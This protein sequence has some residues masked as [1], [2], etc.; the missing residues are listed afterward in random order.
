[1]FRFITLM[2]PPTKKRK[3]MRTM[4]RRS[5]RRSRPVALANPPR[6]AKRRRVG[7]AR[8][9]RHHSPAMRAKISRA[10]KRA[11][12]SRRSGGGSIR[13]MR[14]SRPMAIARRRSSRRRSSASSG[15]LYVIKG[16][17][18]NP[19]RRNR[20][21]S[22][23]RRNPDFN[24][25]SLRGLLSKDIL[26]VAAG[27]VTAS[28]ATGYVLNKFGTSLPMATST[29]GLMAYQLAIPMIGAYVLR[30]KYKSFA[31]GLAVGGIVMAITSVMKTGLGTVGA[32]IVQTPMG[33]FALAGEIGGRRKIRGLNA[34]IGPKTYHTVPDAVNAPVFASG[35]WG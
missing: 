13:R 23:R 35:A 33:S 7:V 28:V 14:R 18:L 31:V 4:R 8:K 20:R 25:S 10:V 11:M 32:S 22:R 9:S 2:N 17:K 24:I 26:I 34:Y 29:Y 19:P 5:A 1:M 16:R 30:N 3:N 15:G 27:A 6:R 12:R 21:F